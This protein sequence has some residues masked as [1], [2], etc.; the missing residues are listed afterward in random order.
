MRGKKK[1]LQKLRRSTRVIA[2]KIN[3]ED[4][5]DEDEED[6]DDETEEGVIRS[7]HLL[8]SPQ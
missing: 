1:R 8:T 4:S 7:P 3:E 2:V 5:D 6:C